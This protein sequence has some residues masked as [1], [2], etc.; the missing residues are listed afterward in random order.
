MGFS[1]E[2]KVGPLDDG[3]DGTGL[4]A[5]IFFVQLIADKGVGDIYTE[6][7]FEEV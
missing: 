2:F 3:V 7:I 5:L 4:L 6:L 1:G